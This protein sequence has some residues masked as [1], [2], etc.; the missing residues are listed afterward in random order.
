MDKNNVCFENHIVEG[1]DASTF[2]EKKNG[3]GS[4]KNVNYLKG[5]RIKNK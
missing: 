4:D 2:E 5:I 1:A 3:E